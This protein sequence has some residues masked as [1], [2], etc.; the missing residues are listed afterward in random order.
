MFQFRHLTLSKG[1]KPQNFNVHR[2]VL[3]LLYV[4]KKKGL[5]H[6]DLDSFK[7]Y[8]YCCLPALKF[9]VVLCIV[10]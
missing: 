8:L 1:R 9:Q 5:R 2:P 7:A 3:Q 10:V 6:G 4:K